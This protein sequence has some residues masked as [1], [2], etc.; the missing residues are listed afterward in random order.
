[1]R[2]FSSH[3]EDVLAYQGRS[4]SKHLGRWLLPTVSLHILKC[5]V[6]LY[7]IV[8]FVSFYV[9]FVCKCVLYCCHR[10]T[11]QLQL[12]NILFIIYY[13]RTFPEGQPPP[14]STHNPPPQ[15][16]SCYRNSSS[17]TGHS[18]TIQ[19]HID[20]DYKLVSSLLKNIPI[21]RKHTGWYLPIYH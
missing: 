17:K 6:I 20:I 16:Q 10:V 1:M 3:S 7:C 11:T 15:Q 19:P 18:S 21:A 5:G 8:C 13:H 14:A 4:C 2:T 12:T 9:L